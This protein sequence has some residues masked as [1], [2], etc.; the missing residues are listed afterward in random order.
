MKSDTS[1]MHFFYWLAAQELLTA[2][3]SVGGGPGRVFLDVHFSLY[4]ITDHS[5]IRW[6][7]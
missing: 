4:N 3:N 5:R 7:T 6:I 2:S 1:A